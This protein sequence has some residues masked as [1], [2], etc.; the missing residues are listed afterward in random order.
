[1]NGM[2]LVGGFVLLQLVV[3]FIQRSFDSLREEHLRQVEG[4]L[5]RLGFQVW[6]EALP[7]EVASSAC[8]GLR[9][10]VVRK[11]WQRECEGRQQYIVYLAHR[12]RHATQ[13]SS[14]FSRS[15]TT[16][17]F[18]ALLTHPDL[19]QPGFALLPATKLNRILS[20][21][22]LHGQPAASLPPPLGEHFLGF[23]RE[24]QGAWNALSSPA[25]QAALLATPDLYFWAQGRVVCFFAD[26]TG[27]FSAASASR[28]LPAYQRLV[29]E[30]ASA[31]ARG[32]SA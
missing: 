21:S 14:K 17:S 13:G 19:D 2:L 24:F 26:A 32:G 8:W 10:P 1:M 29:D 7:A 11:A 23:S 20:S 6:P 28:F 3:F 9:Q 12:I 4:E 27:G 31:S 22:D 15:S 30:L 16:H 5:T 25:V 18:R